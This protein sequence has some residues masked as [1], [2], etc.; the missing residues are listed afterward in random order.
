MLPMIVD[1]VGARMDGIASLWAWL[2]R[3]MPGND[4]IAQK[5]LLGL[6]AA[7]AVSA[8]SWL[9]WKVYKGLRNL[10]RYIFEHGDERERL[11]RA[12]GAVRG[13]R[14]IWLTQPIS[15]PQ[16][17]RLRI[18]SSIPIITLANLKGGVGKSTITANVAAML[19]LRGER[20]LVIDLDFQGSL[21]SMVLGEDSATQRPAN[22]A[23]S[24]SS[25]ALTGDMS[26]TWL[27]T[28]ALPYRAT[29]GKWVPTTEEGRPL[30]LFALTGFYDLARVE[31]RLLV[32]WLIKDRAADMPYFLTKLL[33][34]DEVRSR[35]DRILI[36]APPRLST[37]CIQALCASTHLLIP[38][39][40]DRLSAEAVVTFTDEIKSQREAGL[41]PHLKHLG[42][43]GSM[44]PAAR[45]GYPKS[46]ITYLEDQLRERKSAP[47]LLPQNCWIDETATLGAAAGITI[48]VLSSDN[49][50]RKSAREAFK[51]LA[52][53]IATEA[54]TKSR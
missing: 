43:V 4:E 18:E 8:L 51:L 46:T 48:A 39:V 40:M 34:S 42:V 3:V 5:I 1:G 44:M 25:E 33:H 9:G 49:D 21:S 29:S 38:T 53:Y 24:K 16:D 17:Y 35:Y 30:G 14:G 27:V 12:R 15:P 7:A 11:E 26:A 52:D 23:L 54:P 31:N 28:S 36:D 6:I 32:E 47:A 10:V 20:V 19:A 45:V 2:L 22:N 13:D 50:V 37:A 41:C